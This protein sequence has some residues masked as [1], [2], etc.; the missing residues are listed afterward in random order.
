[1]RD[2]RDG[3][4][5]P[6]IAGS[7]LDKDS[8]TFR[9]DLLEASELVD[10][11]YGRLDRA[12]VIPARSRQEIAS[13]FDEPLPDEPQAMEAILQEV[14]AKIVA[15]STL[16]L[17]PRFFGYINGSGN[18]AAIVGDLLA[19]AMN[20]I[21]AKWHFSPAASEVERRVIQLIEAF[22]GYP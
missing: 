15:N 14:E 3:I 10:R 16:C 18:Q 22:I 11:L 9:R 4:A 2:K 1:M 21:C 17:S 20:Q 13:L 12:P 5:K 8:K 7:N 19:S 6:F